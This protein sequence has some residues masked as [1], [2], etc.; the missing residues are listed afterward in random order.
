MGDVSA[1][2]AATAGDGDGDEGDG[3]VGSERARRIS[4]RWLPLRPPP[5][6]CAAHSTGR[7]APGA[8]KSLVTERSR[9]LS[10]PSRHG[11]AKVGGGPQLLLTAVRG[12]RDER[13]ERVTD[14]GD[15]TMR[16]AAGPSSMRT[17]RGDAG[18]AGCEKPS[19]SGGGVVLDAAAV[20]A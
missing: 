9:A 19:S 20:E 8:R 7:S 11:I 2:A 13:D 16:P 1:I 3:G 6:P 17:P 12:E 4:V 18:T 5:S 10:G 15:A 14:G